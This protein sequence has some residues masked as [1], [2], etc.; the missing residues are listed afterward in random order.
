[1]I[2]R[3]FVLIV[4]LL[5][6][7]Q[8]AYC[9]WEKDALWAYFNALS[10]GDVRQLKALLSPNFEYSF[11]KSDKLYTLNRADELKSI[12]LILHDIPSNQFDVP[13]LFLWDRKTFEK[14]PLDQWNKFKIKLTIVFEDSPKV[15]TD[16]IFR[17]AM[18]ELD[19]TMIITLDDDHK[20]S[21]I[22]EDQRGAKRAGELSFGHLKQIYLK[23]LEE[24]C[25][26]DNGPAADGRPVVGDFVCTLF[27]KKIREVLLIRIDKDSAGGGT[28][29]HYY[30][31]N[32]RRITNLDF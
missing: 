12:E 22:L 27:D 19:E 10:K 15:Y 30:W 8:P 9:N 3:I 4:G 7:P 2:A 31:P 32:K 6:F 11:Y 24:T 5:L 13:D 23:G 29:T 25:R 17:G 21:K 1:M 14:L 20:I 26:D 16:T 28:E 18:L